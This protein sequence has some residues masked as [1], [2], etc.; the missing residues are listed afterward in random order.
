MKMRICMYAMDLLMQVAAAV[1]LLLLPQLDCAQR[2]LVPRSEG[3]NF[4]RGFRMQNLT[5]EDQI[6]KTWCA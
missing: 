5:I 6:V 3:S 1:G 2:V 4:Q